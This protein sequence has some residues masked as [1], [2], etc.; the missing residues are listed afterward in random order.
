MLLRR[1]K[2]EG[3]YRA[4]WSST[5]EAMHAGPQLRLPVKYYRIPF[6]RWVAWEQIF[7]VL[8]NTFVL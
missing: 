3:F 7:F 2:P 1:N 5:S 4:L 6:V 8:K